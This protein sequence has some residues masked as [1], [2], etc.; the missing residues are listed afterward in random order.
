MGNSSL[1][2][3]WT[4][5]LNKCRI[6]KFCEEF[7]G[8]QAQDNLGEGYFNFM[9]SLLNF[10]TTLEFEGTFL[11]QCKGQVLDLVDLTTSP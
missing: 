10:T 6:C 7:E 3:S 9:F 5:F 4:I 1:K 2:S 11:K 8:L